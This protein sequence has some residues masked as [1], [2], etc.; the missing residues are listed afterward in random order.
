MRWHSCRNSLM[1]MGGMVISP[2]TFVPAIR[3]TTGSWQRII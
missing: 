2:Q 3:Q 1:S